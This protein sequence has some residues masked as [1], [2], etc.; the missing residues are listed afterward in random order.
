MSNLQHFNLEAEDEAVT[1]ILLQQPEDASR[2]QEVAD[3]VTAKIVH[4]Q[5]K[6]Q[7]TETPTARAPETGTKAWRNFY[8]E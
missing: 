4:R 5:N 2:V 6:G 8:E 1:E 7:R 3:E